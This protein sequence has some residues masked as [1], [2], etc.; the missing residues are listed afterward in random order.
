MTTTATIGAFCD[1]TWPGRSTVEVAAKLAEECGEVAGALIRRA[2]GRK[3]GSDAD[4]RLEIGD[5]L[6]VLST[7]AS[8]HGWDLDE[9]RTERFAAIKE[10]NAVASASPAD[11]LAEL[12]METVESL[13]RV[14]FDREFQIR[15]DQFM[16]R[17]RYVQRTVVAVEDV[18]AP[19]TAGELYDFL[20]GCRDT[21]ATVGVTFR[22][23]PGFWVFGRTS[24]RLAADVRAC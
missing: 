19:A 4:I 22:T 6:I 18:V 2:E 23:A 3:G 5:V 8:R 20:A 13:L 14:S 17:M 11:R 21:L 1:T 10:R 12:V 9:I 16:E 15:G 24:D 7:I